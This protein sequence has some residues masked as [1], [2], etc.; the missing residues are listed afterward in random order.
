MLCSRANCCSKGCNRRLQVSLRHK[1]KTLISNCRSAFA[2][3]FHP[4]DPDEGASEWL[5]KKN[6]GGFVRPTMTDRP[7]TNR[8]TS[9][10]CG[11]QKLSADSSPAS[12]PSLRPLPMT[13]NLCDGSYAGDGFPKTGFDFS[14]SATVSSC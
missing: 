5:Q 11:L 10:F 12:R 14:H 8:S 3:C 4:M 7:R 13:T 2:R 6:G 1:T 9:A